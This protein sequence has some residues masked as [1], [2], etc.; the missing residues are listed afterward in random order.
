[1]AALDQLQID[2]KLRSLYPMVTVGQKF[3]FAG[4]QYTYKGTDVIADQID[5]LLGGAK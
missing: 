2:Y 4:K 5:D 3:V 1:M